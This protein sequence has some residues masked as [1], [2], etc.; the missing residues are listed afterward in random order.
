MQRNK[1]TYKKN[2]RNVKRKE[3]RKASSSELKLEER[4]SFPRYNPGPQFPDR[5]GARIVSSGQY[6]DAGATASTY[7]YVV[8]NSLL[9]TDH[10]GPS[11]V[12]S[13]SLV[14]LGKTYASYRVTRYKMVVDILPRLTSSCVSALGP[15]PENPSPST[16][17]TFSYA[18]TTSGHVQLMTIP[19]LTSMSPNYFKFGKAGPMTAIVGST[20]P[21]TDIDYAGSASSS[22]IFTG[23]TKQVYFVMHQAPISGSFT[24]NTSPTYV[25]HLEQWVE[26]YDRRN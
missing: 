23:P 1:N 26:F 11:I 17:G 20:D 16:A 25:V 24:A 7:G 21:L 13:A 4:L 5:Y 15:L 9:T 12:Q 18:L 22:G 10:S 6:S 3:N 2:P 19:S 14:N 8:L